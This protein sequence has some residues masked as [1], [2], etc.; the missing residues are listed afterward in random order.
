[1]SGDSP[2]DLAHQPSPIA[3]RIRRGEQERL[4]ADRVQGRELPDVELTVASHHAT[5]P[6]RQHVFGLTVIYFLP[7]EAE[8]KAWLAGDIPTPDAAQH[9]GYI[10]RHDQ[11]AALNAKVMGVASQSGEELLRMGQYL[12]PN[13]LLL[14]DVEMRLGS[15]LDLPTDEHGLYRR[16]A[17]LTD[18][19][20]IKRMFPA[21]ER[22][23]ASAS[24]RQVL[25]WL[26][27][28]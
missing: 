25:S 26:E 12:R 3:E 16:I 18:G 10:R 8:G 24:A 22:T 23:D 2:A 15:A 11:F 4:L 19:T 1:M 14:A 9:R 20:R 28:Q 21:V 13:H 7:G 27:A 5:V 17:L 6:L